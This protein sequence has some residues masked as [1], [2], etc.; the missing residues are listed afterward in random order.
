MFGVFVNGFLWRVEP[1]SPANLCVSPVCP[2]WCDKIEMFVRLN[3]MGS[4]HGEYVKM[5]DPPVVFVR[6][7]NAK[8][9]FHVDALSNTCSA[10][11]ANPAPKIISK[12]SNEA[13]RFNI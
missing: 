11:L 3:E 6:G 5:F 7:L 13:I 12:N 2:L 1:K 10:F 9:C 8:S 4:A